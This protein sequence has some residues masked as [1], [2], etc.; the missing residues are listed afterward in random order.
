MRIKSLLVICLFTNLVLG[1]SSS[2]EVIKHQQKTLKLWELLSFTPDSASQ[3]TGGYIYSFGFGG[4]YLKLGEDRSYL[5]KQYTD[6]HNPTSIIKGNTGSYKLRGDTLF[7]NFEAFALDTTQARNS[8]L[9]DSLIYSNMVAM[10]VM[11]PNDTTSVEKRIQN[12]LKFQEKFKNDEQF[13][14]FHEMNYYFIKRIG[15][16]IFLVKSVFKNFFLN[17]LE[18]KEG[19]LTKRLANGKNYF[20]YH[21]TKID[22]L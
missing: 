15:D 19:L 6:V 9:S 4:G 7:L 14:R 22:S 11:P 21:F 3:I 16:T 5:K 13:V 10:F 17:E 12:V 18:Q 1:C 20:M 2:K 8:F